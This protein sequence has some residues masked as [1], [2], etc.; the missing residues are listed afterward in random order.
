LNHSKDTPVGPADAA[1][2]RFDLLA[3]LAVVTVYLSF[4]LLVG[5]VPAWL[6]RPA[7]AGGSVSIG[8]VLGAL[9]TVFLVAA[10]W[11]YTRVRNRVDRNGA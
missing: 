2:A 7:V 10:A 5:F 6:A 11:F 3:T 8:L 1:G 4:M 9:V